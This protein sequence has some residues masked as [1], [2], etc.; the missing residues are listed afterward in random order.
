M[1]NR[2]LSVLTVASLIPPTEIKDTLICYGVS[3]FFRTEASLDLK[4]RL[5]PLVCRTVWIWM[6]TN[7]L[8]V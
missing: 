7:I 2:D 4:Y 6:T 8:L 5:I 3:F 1:E